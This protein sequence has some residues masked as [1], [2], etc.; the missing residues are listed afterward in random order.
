[1]RGLVQLRSGGRWFAPER[2]GDVQERRRFS[3]HTK[4]I[5]IQFPNGDVEYDL[6]RQI[7]PSQ[8]ETFRRNSVLWVVTRVEDEV[9]HVERVDE[10]KST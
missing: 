10:R 7:I 4:T 1:M 3:L 5:V 9:V 8:G 2:S 6:T